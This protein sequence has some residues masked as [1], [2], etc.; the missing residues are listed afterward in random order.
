MVH[1][2]VAW[3]ADQ[4]VLHQ[5]AWAVHHQVAWDQV[6]TLQLEAHH[7]AVAEP[8]TFSVTHSNEIEVGVHLLLRGEE[9]NSHR[10]RPYYQKHSQVFTAEGARFQPA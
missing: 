2:Q 5:V 6:A 10:F 1:L 4:E 7:Q 9:G 8:E 3:L